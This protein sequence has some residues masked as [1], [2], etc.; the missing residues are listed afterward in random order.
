MR[1]PGIEP[2]LLAWKAKVIPL[3][4][5]RK[6]YSSVD[7]Y[8][9]ELFALWGAHTCFCLPVVFSYAL[10]FA[11]TAGCADFVGLVHCVFAASAAN[12]MASFV[13][14]SERWFTVCHFVLLANIYV[15]FR[16]CVDHVV[17]ANQKF[18]VFF[19]YF[20]V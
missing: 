1:S 18:P 6:C 13:S 3:D 10:A 4:H 11:E 2:G 15:L 5:D 8:K 19:C 16:G 17:S 9:N 20:T 14:F 12:Y 7:P